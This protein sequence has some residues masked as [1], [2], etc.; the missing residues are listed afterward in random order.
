M[1]YSDLDIKFEAPDL[2][3]SPDRSSSSSSNSSSSSDSSTSSTSSSESAPIFQ[4]AVVRHYLLSI[5]GVKPSAVFLAHINRSHLN[6][7]CRDVW[8]TPKGQFIRMEIVKHRAT[9]IRAL[10]ACRDLS[11]VKNASESL[12][13]LVSFASTRSIK[14]TVLLSHLSNDQRFY[15]T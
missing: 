2:Y 12:L 8:S 6:N 7:A 14:T 3:V 9:F 15:P 1:D 5:W 11:G 13:E 4:K 10:E